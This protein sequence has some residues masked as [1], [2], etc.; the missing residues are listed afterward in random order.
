LE[1]RNSCSP[2]GTWFASSCWH[3]PTYLKSVA[4]PKT[5]ISGFQKSVFLSVKEY[6]YT[7]LKLSKFQF[8]VD[9]GRVNGRNHEKSSLKYSKVH[10][11][12][13]TEKG[14][15]YL[16]K[17]VTNQDFILSPHC[18]IHV[19][20]SC[21][22]RTHSSCERQSIN[23]MVLHI[24]KQV[25][26]FWSSFRRTAF[27]FSRSLIISSRYWYLEKGE[28]LVTCS[29]TVFMPGPASEFLLRNIPF[30]LYKTAFG[31]LSVSSMLIGRYGNNILLPFGTS[32]FSHIC[33]IPCRSFNYQ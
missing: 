5:K 32:P 8:C 10:H 33:T 2:S 16:E 24:N 12:T 26:Y 20:Q 17:L 27:A 29:C 31:I 21:E 23:H 13:C 28:K 25:A 7:F 1:L 11:I 6:F 14:Y 18:K 3:Q 30:Y 19:S 22:V 15:L 9:R 4:I